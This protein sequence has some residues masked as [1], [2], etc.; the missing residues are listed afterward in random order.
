MAKKKDARWPELYLTPM[1][2][3]VRTRLYIVW[4]STCKIAILILHR[5]KIVPSLRQSRFRSSLFILWF[6]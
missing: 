3:S 1:D 2:V 6:A 5:I 4:P